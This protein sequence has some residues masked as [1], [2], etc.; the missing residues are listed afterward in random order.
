MDY[1][2][3]GGWLDIGAGGTSHKVM[4]GGAIVQDD[5]GARIDRLREMI[6]TI[7]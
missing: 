2:R 4:T 3:C 7:K 1:D 6:V 5:I